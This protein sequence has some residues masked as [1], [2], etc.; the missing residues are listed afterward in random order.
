M[1]IALDAWLQSRLNLYTWKSCLQFKLLV[2]NHQTTPDVTGTVVLV[3]ST[4]NP[5]ILLLCNLVEKDENNLY[6][7][8]MASL[9]FIHIMQ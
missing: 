7:T 6:H 9:L 4:Y 8:P 2:C 5:V 3:V 1:R